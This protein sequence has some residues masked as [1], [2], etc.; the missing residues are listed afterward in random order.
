VDLGSQYQNVSILDFIGAKDEE[1]GGDNWSY[2]TY[3]S[4]SQNEKTINIS[5]PNFY[6]PDAFPVAEPTV[7]DH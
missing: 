7:L 3:K 6:R 4:S 5:T 2:R 1:S